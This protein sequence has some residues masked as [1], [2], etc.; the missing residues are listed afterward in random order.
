MGKII[1]D[2]IRENTTPMEGD[3][4]K[5]ILNGTVASTLTLW[6]SSDHLIGGL[7]GFVMIRE[8]MVALIVPLKSQNYFLVVFEKGTDLQTVE[9]TRAKLL[10]A[11][12]LLKE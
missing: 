6:K 2:A 3:E 8:K 1:H 7:Q 5:H 12:E 9:S 4:E 11:I 10:E